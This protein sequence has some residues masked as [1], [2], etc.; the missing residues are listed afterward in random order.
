MSNKLHTLCKVEGAVLIISKRDAFFQKLWN[1]NTLDVDSCWIDVADHE[2]GVHF[3]W[4]LAVLEKN[5]FYC[6]FMEKAAHIFATKL[7]CQKSLSDSFSAT[8]N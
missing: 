4:L 3:E 8:S 1:F 5:A 6:N 7:E 2:F